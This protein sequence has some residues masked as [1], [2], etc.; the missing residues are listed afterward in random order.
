MTKKAS[1]A[2]GNASPIIHHIT[3]FL[4]GDIGKGINQQIE[5]IPDKDWVCLRDQDTLFLLPHQG[6][7]IE[8]IVKS[9]PSFDVIGCS[10]NRLASTFQLWQNE[11]SEVTDIVYHQQVAKQ[12]YAEY[13]IDLSPVHEGEHLAGLFYLF[14]KE[15]WNE[16]KFQEKSIQFDLIF[17]NELYKKGKKMAVAK[18]LYLFHLYRLGSKNPPTAI[19]HI[20]HCQDMS[21][22]AEFPLLNIGGKSVE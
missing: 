19:N 6:A 7:M 18:G 13:G 8:N 9:N 20:L 14:R 2:E 21:K 3:P 4:T 17:C 10:T 22:I 1:L 15:L 16:I 12:A 5:H 11:F